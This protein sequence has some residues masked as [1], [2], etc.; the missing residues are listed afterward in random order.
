M[1]LPRSSTSSSSS[2]PKVQARRD[3]K[4][5]GLASPRRRRRRGECGSIREAISGNRRATRV[6]SAPRLASSYPLPSP[7]LPPGRHTLLARALESEWIPETVIV[8]F[9]KRKF[10]RRFR[11]SFR[12]RS[13]RSFSPDARAEPRL[14][15]IFPTLAPR[16]PPLLHTGATKTRNETKHP[17]VFPSSVNRDPRNDSGP[18]FWTILTGR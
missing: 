13:I 17:S 12:G 18:V 7:P 1:D 16:W 2:T 5:V 14:N 9:K 6:L 15:V 4:N 3:S 8:E 10:S 11:G